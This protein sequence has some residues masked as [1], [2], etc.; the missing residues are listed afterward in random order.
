MLMRR[1]SPPGMKIPCVSGV[2]AAKIEAGIPQGGTPT[3]KG[4]VYPYWHSLAFI[5]GSG[6]FSW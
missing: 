1:S 2:L 4:P 3:G 5:R 6:V